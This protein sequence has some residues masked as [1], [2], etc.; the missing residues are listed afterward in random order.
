MDK[1]EA[2][3]ALDNGT[4]KDL[5]AKSAIKPAPKKKTKAKK[6]D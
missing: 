3:K 5:V 6:E 1:A 4:W 2:K